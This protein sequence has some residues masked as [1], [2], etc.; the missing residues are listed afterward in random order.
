MGAWGLGDAVDTAIDMDS[1]GVMHMELNYSGNSQELEGLKK[2]SK[3]AVEA[4]A[5][6]GP[7]IRD[8]TGSGVGN[9]PDENSSSSSSSSGKVSNPLPL[10]PS[11]PR[12]S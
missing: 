10:P 6:D 5:G 1:N 8:Y 2:S 12:P 4:R 11:L 9:S 7:S 3:T